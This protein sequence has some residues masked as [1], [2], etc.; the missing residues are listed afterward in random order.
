M[1]RSTPASAGV[2]F[3]LSEFGSACGVRPAVAGVE[4]LAFLYSMNIL[5]LGCLVPSETNAHLEFPGYGTS[6]G[7]VVS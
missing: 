7:I 5:F 2:M 4:P 1:A 6:C 3:E